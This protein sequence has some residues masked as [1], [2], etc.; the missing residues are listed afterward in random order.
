MRQVSQTVP[1]SA[2]WAAAA[3]RAVALG[4]PDLAALAVRGAGARPLPAGVAA[5]VSKTQGPGL[6]VAEAVGLAAP[7][8]AGAAL[9]AAVLGRIGAASDADAARDPLGGLPAAAL[10]DGLAGLAAK[11]GPPLGAQPRIAGAGRGV[12]LLRALGAGRAA[13]LGST[14]AA[15]HAEAHGGPLPGATARALAVPLPPALKRIAVGHD[16]SLPMGVSRR[17]A[18]R[19]PPLSPAGGGRAT[20]RWPGRPRSGP[21]RGCAAR[22]R[23]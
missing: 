1:S 16:G 22:C 18:S 13:S 21:R 19:R 8:Q 11:P 4:D 17:Q 20:M 2:G 5:A 9:A 14:P 3:P 15:R 7:G 23:R 6:L 10:P 12:L